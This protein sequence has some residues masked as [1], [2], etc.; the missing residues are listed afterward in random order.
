MKESDKGWRL[1][2]A[3]AAYAE[4]MFHEVLG[5][6]EASIAA[7]EQSLEIMP[8][9]PPA[10]L[11]VGSIAYQ[12]GNEAEGRRLFMTLPS[13]PDGAGDLCEVIDKAG[14]FLIHE[15]R[16]AEGTELYEAA[17][18]RFPDR[19][20]LYQGLGCCAGHEQSFAKAIDA[21]RK[22]LDLE[23]HNQ[24]FTNDLGWSLFL[25][26]QLQEAEQVLLKATAMDPA[27]ARARENLRLCQEARAE[28]GVRGDRDAG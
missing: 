27:D 23:P 14:D 19:A 17:V 15:E 10:V 11:T 21:S 22:A 2:Q 1:F 18:E 7:A 3:Q 9:Y 20:V 24:K 26:G 8:D 12:R 13:L 5:D 6:M 28:T 4:S 16:Y 25:A